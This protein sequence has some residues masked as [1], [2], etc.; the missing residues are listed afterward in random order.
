MHIKQFT[1]GQNL[2]FLWIVFDYQGPLLIFTNVPTASKLALQLLFFLIK[3]KVPL[4][5]LSFF[6]SARLLSFVAS[7]VIVFAEA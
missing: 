3:G 5:F 2:A 1:I 6:V 7:L 4:V